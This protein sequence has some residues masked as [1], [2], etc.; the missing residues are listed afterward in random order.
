MK[1]E[2][3]TIDELKEYKKTKEYQELDKKDKVMIQARLLEN[4]IFDNPHRKLQKVTRHTDKDKLEKEYWKKH[5]QYKK[6]ISRLFRK[7]YHF[8]T[9]PEVFIEVYENILYRAEFEEIFSSEYVYQQKLR[10]FET[11]EQP[12]KFK[13]WIEKSKKRLKKKG[14][15]IR[16]D[17]EKNVKKFAREKLKILKDNK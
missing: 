15:E 1:I 17:A 4:K 5:K 11:L 12:Q 16:E 14:I 3:Y 13:K 9:A 6:Q 7:A 10:L 2:N 8:I